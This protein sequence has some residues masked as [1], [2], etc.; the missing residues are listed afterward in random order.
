M[1]GLLCQIHINNN[2]TQ[3]QIVYQTDNEYKDINGCGVLLIDINK[4]IITSNYNCE[5]NLYKK[6]IYL[7]NK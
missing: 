6:Y 5:V 1:K 7:N 3:Y 2:N 4:Y